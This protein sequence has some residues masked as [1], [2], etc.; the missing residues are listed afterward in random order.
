MV[1]L[2]L[3]SEKAVV[4]MTEGAGGDLHIYAADLRGQILLVSA[5][6][7]IEFFVILW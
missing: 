6:Y 2:D 7:E 4:A 5:P 1:H 3:I